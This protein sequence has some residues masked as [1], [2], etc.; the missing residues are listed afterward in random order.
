MEVVEAADSDSDDER[1]AGFET[2]PDGVP[3][4][5][6]DRSKSKA[7]DAFPG[8]FSMAASYSSGRSTRKE[9][10][11]GSCCGFVVMSWRMF[12][13]LG[14]PVDAEIRYREA[15]VGKYHRDFREI[16]G[17]RVCSPDGSQG[18]NTVLRFR[19]GVAGKR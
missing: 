18:A 16:H 3:K 7:G 17:G 10:C 4:A 11:G 13:I 15:F 1:D 8:K 12:G 5:D 14:K 6:G 9:W 2:F 19:I